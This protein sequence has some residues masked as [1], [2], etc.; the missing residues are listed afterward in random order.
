MPPDPFSYLLEPRATLAPE[1][2]E[3]LGETAAKRYI[4]GQTPLNETIRKLADQHDLNPHQI[5]RVCET[6]NLAT[7][8]A[9]WPRMREKEK[10][11]FELADAKKIKGERA[12][13]PADR[14]LAADYAGPPTGIPRPGLTL[15]AL[16]G[17]DAKAGHEGLAG[18][19]ERQRLQVALQKKA[20]ERKRLRDQVLV[21]GMEAETAEKLAYDAVKQEVLGGRPVSA[22]LDA[23]RA[24]GLA[25]LASDLLPKFEERLIAE[26]SG[27]ARAGL[28]KRA[29]GR[30]PE[31]LVSDD[32][33]ATTIVNGAHPVLVSLDTVDKKNGIVA[34]LLYNL[35]RIDDEM[36]VYN[37]KLREL[38]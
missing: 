10:I 37:Q 22:I 1:E 6:A 23:A 9:L 18:P 32:L 5:E 3:M 21:A 24:A 16:L 8:Q 36:R 35:L 13:K 11:A 34:N 27:S 33:G 28:E 26:S 2:L 30:A 29:V 7:H 4:D 15:A 31:D 19:S 17:T 38:G 12:V 14:A 20:A 25:K